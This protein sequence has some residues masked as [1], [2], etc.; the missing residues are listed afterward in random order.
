M[1]DLVADNPVPDAADNPTSEPVSSE[2]GTGQTDGQAQ[3]AAPAELFKGIDPNRLP[4]EI[5][6][7]YDSMLR[8]YR[9]KTARLAETIK[10]EVAKSIDPYKSKAEQYD[11]IAAQEEFVKQWNEYAQRSQN[12]NQNP[13]DPTDPVLKQMKSQLDEMNRKIQMNEM[14]EITEAF[15]E[16]VNEKGEKIHPEF[17][18]LNDIVIGKISNSGNEEPFSLLRAAV[19]LAGGATP[20]EKLANGYKAAKAAHDA[21][22]ELGKKAGMGRIQSKVANGTQPASHSLGDTLSVTDKRPKNAREALELAR[23]GVMV[24]RD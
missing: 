10:A 9:E 1:S 23:K 6:Q 2:N 17:D 19:E 4:P 3:G 16:A 21:I 11:Q 12:Q 5:K 13:Q 14:S 7:H 22:F 18:T 20:Q 15:A 8:D 24:S